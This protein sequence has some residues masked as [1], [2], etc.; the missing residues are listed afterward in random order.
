MAGKRCDESE[1]RIY[2]IQCAGSKQPGAGTFTQNGLP[3]R[4]VANKPDE[5]RE[6]ECVYA[7][8]DDTS[9]S[10]ISWRKTLLDYN[11]R[12]RNTAANPLRLLPAWQLYQNSIYSRLVTAYGTEHAYILSA[13][14]GLINAEFLT[15]AYDITFSRG[16]RIP[17]YKWR[18]KYNCYCKGRKRR[19]SEYYDDLCQL[20]TESEVP[21]VF[22][23]SKDYVPLFCRLTQT[24][25]CRKIVFYNSKEPPCAPGCDCD[26]K[27]FNAKRNQNWQYDCAKA[28]MDGRIT[29]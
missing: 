4:F 12:Y 5:E 3:V 2:V 6:A 8:P 17:K 27:P 1:P 26:L 29:I 21:I 19:N 14:W 25:D 7:H 28:F 22:F 11:E 15:P 16:K 18:D 23:G 24:L 9:D 13:G 10:G 20:P